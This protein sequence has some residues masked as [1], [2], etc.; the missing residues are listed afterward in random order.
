MNTRQMLVRIAISLCI[1]LTIPGFSQVPHIFTAG[2]TAK[3]EEVNA[4]FQYLVDQINALVAGSNALIPVGTIMAWHKDFPNTPPLPASWVECKG[5]IL[6]DPSSPYDGQT[7]P[8]LNGDLMFLRG[9]TAS[10]IL[11]GD[12]FQDHRH[13]RNPEQLGESFFV[14]IG[15]PVASGISNIF[16]GTDTRSYTITGFA[17]NGS[18]GFETR[19]RNMSV[20]WIMKVR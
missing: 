8:N 18:A 19:P 20:V 15:P 13:Y 16:T 6:N 4:N 7:I 11:Q 1:V 12:M 14:N 5:Q 9:S 3:A 10:G 2:D 17:A